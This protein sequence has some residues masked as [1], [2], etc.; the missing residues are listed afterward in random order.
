VVAVVVCAL[1]DPKASERVVG[2]AIAAKNLEVIGAP[3]FGHPLVASGLGETF[4]PK[5]K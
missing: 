5:E 2:R 3:E 4:Q 1:E